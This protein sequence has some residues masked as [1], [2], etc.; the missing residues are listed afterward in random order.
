MTQKRLAAMRAPGG[1]GLWGAQSDLQVD[2]QSAAR[3]QAAL[4]QIALLAGLDAGDSAQTDP[5]RMENRA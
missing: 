4:D 1:E 5:T 3:R 2:P